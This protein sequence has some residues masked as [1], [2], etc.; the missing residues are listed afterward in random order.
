VN[1]L[2]HST[3]QQKQGHAAAAPAQ[4]K[5]LIARVAGAAGDWD[6]VAG[7]VV[8]LAEAGGSPAVGDLA[9]RLARDRAGLLLD[10]ATQRVLLRCAALHAPPTDLPGTLDALLAADTACT[11]AGE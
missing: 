6:A 7:L 5:V 11:P 9:A 2:H 10:P 1:A 4:A 8:G 3:A